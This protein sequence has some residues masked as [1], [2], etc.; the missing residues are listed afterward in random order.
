MI[1]KAT[2]KII[3]KVVG[4]WCRENKF[5]VLKS[6][7]LSYGK[8]DGQKNILLLFQCHSSGWEPYKGSKFTVWLQQGTETEINWKLS[9][10]LTSQLTIEDLL[11]IRAKQNQVL[12]K[13]PSPPAEYIQNIIRTFEKTFRDPKP[14]IDLYLSDWK[15]VDAPYLITDD[16]WYRYFSEKDVESWAFLLLKYIQKITNIPSLHLA[17]S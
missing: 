1:A 6:S 17:N 2:Y 5:K 15:L 3:R 9:S 7:L 10:R 8:N 4:P 11:I 12:S 13:I 14:Y 16:I